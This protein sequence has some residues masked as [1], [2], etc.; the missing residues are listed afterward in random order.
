M[1][2]IDYD[3]LITRELAD[4]DPSTLHTRYIDCVRYIEPDTGSVI[5]IKT[6]E[7]IAD[8]MATLPHI[9]DLDFQVMI[10]VRRLRMEWVA[11]YEIARI[12]MWL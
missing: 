9:S 8:F 10:N 6:P 7:S 3:E 2:M 5:R 1:L 4:L 12:K 11:A